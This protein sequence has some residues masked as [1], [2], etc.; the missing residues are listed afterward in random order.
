MHTKKER[1]L[2]LHRCYL[3]CSLSKRHLKRYSLDAL[4]VVVVL[5]LAGGA[6]LALGGTGV[7]LA[8]ALLPLLDRAGG[9]ATGGGGSSGGGGLDDSGHGGGGGS[10]G[11]GDGDLG[12]GAGSRLGGSRR[13]SGRG[14]GSSRRGGSG[15]GRSTTP[16]GRAR[17]HVV[18]GNGVV[19]AQLE[20]VLVAS[21]DTGDLDGRRRLGSRATGNLNLSARDVELGTTEGRSAV[22]T[23][24]LDTEEVL[25]SGGV[26][27]KVE[28]DLAEVVGLESKT[29]AVSSL[30]GT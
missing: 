12:R 14:R 28:S 13:G 6:G 29:V 23:N 27:G 10:S 9:G 25:A 30:V 11:G 26:L 20:A 8:T 7:A 4:R 18:D 15:T 5:G 19:D 16:D 3:S 1:K 24:V 2:R 21:V 22:E 17:G